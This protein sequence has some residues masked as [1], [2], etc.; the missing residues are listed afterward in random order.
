MNKEQ[1]RLKDNEIAMDPTELCI[2]CD[3]VRKTCELFYV[4]GKM[5]IHYDKF[6]LEMDSVK[7]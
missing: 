1:T 7:G 6:I 5:M 3:A 2:R 4:V